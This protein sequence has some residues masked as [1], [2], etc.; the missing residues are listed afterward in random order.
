M[1]IIDRYIFKS[2]ISTFFFCAIFLYFLFIIGDVF[3]F[4]DEILRE[5][6]AFSALFYFY[7]YMMPF[8]MT[9]IAPISCVLACVFLLGNLNRHNE[10]TAL[11]ASGVSL[12][13]ILQPIIFGSLIIS[14]GLF[15]LNDR[16]VPR[17][18]MLANKVRYEK[19][20]LGK[21]GSSKILTNI[22]LYGQGNNIIFTKKFDTGKNTLEDVIIHR[23]DATQSVLSKTSVRIMRWVGK[24][25]KERWV[26]NDVVLYKIN[27]RG[28]FV[29]SP[30][31]FP[32][33][34]IRLKEKPIDFM[35]NQ[36]QPQ[37]MSYG[38]LKKYL[39]V[40]LG[41]SKLALMR[42]SVDLHYKISFPFSCITMILV[43]APFTLVTRRGAALVGMVKGILMALAYIPLVALCL[44]LGKGGILP[45][46]AAAWMANIILGGIGL[47]LTLK[48]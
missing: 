13:M 41:G 25:G 21:R 15:I 24:D 14:A 6:I 23:Q 29:G 5:R 16:V 4:I 40:F 22:A 44:A 11:K 48:N 8:V 35:N 30:E 28:E 31:I 3:G 33:L 45:P 38:Q 19:L 42:Y 18:M 7:Y 17:A 36:W 12:L 20:E 9:Q 10:I 46:V 34:E 27:R 37:F 26:G 2:Y 39:T 47:I 1:K 43:A 32:E